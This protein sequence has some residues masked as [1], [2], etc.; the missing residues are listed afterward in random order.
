MTLRIGD[1][2]PN[3]AA[4]TTHGPIHLH[5]WI[6]DQWAMLFSHPKDFTPVCTTELAQIA[7]HAA[8]FVRRGCKVMGL[9]VDAVDTHRAWLPDIE[10]VGG[11]SVSYPM[12]GDADLAVA[13]ALGMLPASAQPGVRTAADNATVRN[14]LVIGPDKRVKATLSYPMSTGRNVAELLRLL[15]SLQLT[16]TRAVATPANWNLGDEVII[17]LRCQTTRPG[18]STHRAGRRPH[19]TSGSSA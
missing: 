11:M 10:R 8:D 1:L 9:S 15:D 5:P 14:V 13:K 6:G 3:L 4:E 18:G 19:R 2:V 16:A 17:P 12:I 7:R